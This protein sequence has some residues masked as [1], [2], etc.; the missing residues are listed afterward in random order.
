MHLE[1]LYSHEITKCERI[2]PDN[3]D[4]LLY[5][6]LTKK[7]AIKYCGYRKNYLSQNLSEME[8][9]L[10]VCKV[11]TG[12]LREP[13]LYKSNT[14]CLV[15]SEMSEELNSVKGIQTSVSKLDIKC[16]TLRDCNWNAKLSE[17]SGHLE[18]CLC[19]LI[20]CNKC[21]QVV[22]RREKINHGAML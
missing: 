6:K 4:E 21:K 3:T 20:E 2:T 11:C 14:T 12:I 13:S 22:Q 19:S 15:C 5:V 9:E 18:I 17:A 8:Q 10:A 16:P 7:D 1:A